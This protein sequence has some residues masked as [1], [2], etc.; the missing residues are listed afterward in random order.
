MEGRLWGLADALV[1]WTDTVRIKASKK[2]KNER[3]LKNLRKSS[4]NGC[5][6]RRNRA[7]PVLSDA[8]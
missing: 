8:R 7:L 1:N 3:M 4:P 2:A 6:S 5:G